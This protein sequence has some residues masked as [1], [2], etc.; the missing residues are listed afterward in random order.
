MRPRVR[1]PQ[2]RTQGHSPTVRK[3]GMPDAH[4]AT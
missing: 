3:G 4:V 2:G 1:T